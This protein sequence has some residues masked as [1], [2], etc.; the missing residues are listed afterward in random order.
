M[1]NPTS[2]YPAWVTVLAAL[3]T[4]AVAILATI[5]ALQ[6]LRTAREKLKLEL[7]DRRLSIHEQT[8]DVLSRE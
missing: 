7:F 1:M 3:L 6:Q 2:V 4:P 5:V 8:R